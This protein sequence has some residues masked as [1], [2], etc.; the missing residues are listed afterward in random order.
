MLICI[1]SYALKALNI[2]QNE[3]TINDLDLIGSYDEILNY[4]KNLGSVISFYPIEDGKKIFCKVSKLRQNEPLEIQI[5]EAEVTWS[6]S[7]AEKLHELLITDDESIYCDNL[8]IPSVDVLY[9][10]KMSH[11]FLKNSPHFLK[12]MKD[13]KYLRS[14][15]AKINPRY[16]SF[17]RERCKETYNYSHPKLNVNKDKFFNNDDI[18][19]IYDHDSIHEAVKHLDR[20]AYVYF[21]KDNEEVLCDK[22]KFLNLNENIKLYAVLEEAYVLALERSQIPFKER[23]IDPRKSF[24]IALMKVCTSITSGWFREYAWENYD[25][26]FGLYNDKYAEIF[27]NKVKNKE[28]AF[29]QKNK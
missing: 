10:L 9:L 27:F 25:N 17:Y 15:G 2:L 16:A 28:V 14:I 12:T 5:I 3:R 4:C 21:K 11:R 1:G 20:P 24:E 13:I 7:T 6:G 19:Y 8:L 18:E 23:N 26:V 29:V 22:H